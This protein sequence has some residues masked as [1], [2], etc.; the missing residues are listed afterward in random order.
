M[1][2]AAASVFIKFRLQLE[3]VNVTLFTDDIPNNLSYFRTG[4]RYGSLLL[5]TVVY[6]LVR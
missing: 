6:Y 2:S 5:S 1:V 4:P 3:P